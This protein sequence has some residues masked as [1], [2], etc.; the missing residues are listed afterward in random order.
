MQDTQDIRDYIQANWKYI[1]LR[2]ESLN[3]VLR[4]GIEDP[5]VT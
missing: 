4:I 5:R 2:D 3:P 1:E